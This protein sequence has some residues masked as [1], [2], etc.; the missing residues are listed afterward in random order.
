MNRIIPGILMLVLFA[1]VIMLGAVSVFREAGMP[2]GLGY[3]ILCGISFDAIVYAFCAK[4]SNKTNCPH[5]IPGRLAKTMKRANGPYTRIEV[6]VLI[7]SL[8]LIIG[9]PQFWIWHSLGQAAAFWLLTILAVLLTP[10]FLCAQCANTFCP[11][12][13]RRNAEK[14]EIKL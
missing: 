10:C 9:I 7:L 6:T 3:V 4:C 2:F 1:V 14:G 13:R 5:V 11:L 12:N 8:L